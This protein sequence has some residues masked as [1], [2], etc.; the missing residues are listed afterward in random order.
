MHGFSWFDTVAPSEEP[1]I[2][3]IPWTDCRADIGTKPRVWEIAVRI[4]RPIHHLG[5]RAGPR[6]QFSRVA[7]CS[8][9]YVVAASLYVVAVSYSHRS[10]PHRCTALVTLAEG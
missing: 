2:T 5:P 1:A 9:A 3:G 7:Y 6:L 10:H 8:E 4:P